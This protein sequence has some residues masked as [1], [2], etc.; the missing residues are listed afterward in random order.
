MNILRECKKCK[1]TLFYEVDFRRHN[2]VCKSCNKE[3][4][5][6]HKRQTPIR[7]YDDKYLKL[8]TKSYK[9][10]PTSN[11]WEW[12]GS[13]DYRGEFGKM[14]TRGKT[15]TS[16]R[17][18]WFYNYPNTE[19][20]LFIRHKCGNKKCVN[21]THLESVTKKFSPTKTEPFAHQ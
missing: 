20:N 2:K 4:D 1:K 14:I 3:I 15:T 8:F 11:C 10:N 6:L 7:S 9:I 5:K 21:I 17:Y 16:H 12:T 18:I 19:Q 13:L